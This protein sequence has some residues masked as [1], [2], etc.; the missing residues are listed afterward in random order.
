[1]EFKTFGVIGFG[2]FG[3]FMGRSLASRGDVLVTDADLDRL[4]DFPDGVRAASIH[5]IATADVVVLAIPFS[6]LEPV[7]GQIRDLVPPPT[8]VM[9]VVSTKARAT[10]LLEKVLADHP[11]VLATHPL[12]GP[13]SM[14]RMQ[15]G[16]RV[17][18][19]LQRGERA[20]A[21]VR[22]LEETFGVQIVPMPAEAHDRAMAYMQSL[23]FFIARA[24]VNI[25]IEGLEHRDTLEIPSFQKLVEIAT[26]EEQHTVDMFD[27]SQISNPYAEEARAHF[28]D[29]LAKLQEEIRQHTVG[30]TR[31]PES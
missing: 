12:F 17:V 8:V 28:L 7:L 27:T 6:A 22:F 4:A 13:P 14:E 1:V 29:V 30:S 19:T 23:P 15:P 16:D 24:L 2:H 11:N 21:F 31:A 9:D 20:E 5:E 26:I 3:Q 25:D 10:A 18:V